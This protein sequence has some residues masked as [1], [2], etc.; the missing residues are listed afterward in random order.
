MALAMLKL[1][2]YR[3]RGLLWRSRLVPKAVTHHYI[4]TASLVRLE[5]DWEGRAYKIIG[6][7]VVEANDYEKMLIEHVVTRAVEK[8]EIAW[9]HGKRR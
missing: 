1:W 7:D 8:N 4:K 2:F 6:T 3:L 5:I 9:V